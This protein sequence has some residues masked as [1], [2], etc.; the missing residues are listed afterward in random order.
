MSEDYRIEKV[1]ET[2]I[3]PG[4][5]QPFEVKKHIELLN[6]VW[7][8]NVATLSYEKYK[9]FILT[10]ESKLL[11]F[12][13]SNK[14]RYEVPPRIKVTA[15]IFSLVDFRDSITSPK[16]TELESFFD[17]QPSRFK[18]ESNP[19]EENTQKELSFSDVKYKVREVY[20]NEKAGQLTAQAADEFTLR[21]YRDKIKK[22]SES[23][24][25]LLLEKNGHKAP[26]GLYSRIDPPTD[27]KISTQALIDAFNLNDNRYFS[28]IIK[29]QDGSAVLIYD[30][31]VE[32]YIPPFEEI[33]KTILADYEES[34]LKRLFIEE[35]KVINR[36]LTTATNKGK[37]FLMIANDLGLS[38]ETYE[39]FTRRAPP[40]EFNFSLFNSI[41]N[42]SPGGVTPMLFIKN[43]GYFVHL[44]DKILPEG[45]SDPSVLESTSNQLIQATNYYSGQ[46]LI[47]ELK[48]NELDKSKIN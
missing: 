14:F 38:V 2:M 36:N 11:S 17:I 3:G 21:L 47:L 45:N 26:I 18:D 43:K 30:N 6:T 29:T 25:Q 48:S 40:D 19:G 8:I 44:K 39:N 33:Q 24:N 7:S 28:D 42:L 16:D 31:R 5:I 20:L 41:D 34:E 10:E 22:Y 1:Q 13:E 32:K 12:Y 27:T 23:F 35:G 37:Q 15:I 9:P 4:F 46:S